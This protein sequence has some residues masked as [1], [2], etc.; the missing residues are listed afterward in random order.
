MFCQNC[1]K[2]RVGD[3]AFC[4]QCGSRYSVPQ[5][6]AAGSVQQEGAASAA[7]VESVASVA[8]VTNPAVRPAPAAPAVV[9]GT[10]TAQREK[11]MRLCI[12]TST[13]YYSKAFA[14]IDRGESSFN[15]TAFFIA[16]LFLLYRRQFD[17]WKKMCLPWVVLYLLNNTMAQISLLM[18]NF[19]LISFFQTVG[20][21]LIPA[22]LAVAFFVAKNF[23]RKYK[24]SL[25]RFIAEKGESADESVWKARQPSMKYPLIF[26]VV[27][28]VYNSVLAWLVST[29]LLRGL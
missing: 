12:G 9:Q 19:S 14:K 29:L 17:E 28:V 20:S 8:S 4:P 18:L 22:G 24:E 6:E 5:E 23:N 3:G 25:E 10:D 2:E 16:P 26:L 13:D 21:W 11:I 7:S 1:G 15:L 27:V